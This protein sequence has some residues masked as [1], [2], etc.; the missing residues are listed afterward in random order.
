MFL[1]VAWFPCHDFPPIRGRLLWQQEF[2]VPLN[3]LLLAN[4]ISFSQNKQALQWLLKVAPSFFSLS[5]FKKHIWR[6]HTFKNVLPHKQNIPVKGYMF[7][8]RFV[9]AVIINLILTWHW[10]N[11]SKVISFLISIF[12]VADCR[13][14]LQREELW[15]FHTTCRIIV[16][17]CY[18][19]NSFCKDK[20][21]ST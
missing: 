2:Y 14:A 17:H 15:H 8:L 4:G 10:I 3:S 1:S 12:S 19:D 7:I 5:L 18:G 11:I 16:V 6:D 9:R 13:I 20:Y 21:N